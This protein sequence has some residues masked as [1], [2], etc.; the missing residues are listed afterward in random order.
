MPSPVRHDENGKKKLEHGKSVEVIFASVIDHDIYILACYM[1]Y[2]VLPSPSALLF[3]ISFLEDFESSMEGFLTQSYT[4]NCELIDESSQ[5][6]CISCTPLI[7]DSQRKCLYLIGGNDYH[8]DFRNNGNDVLSC[9]SLSKTGESEKKVFCYRSERRN[10]AIQSAAVWLEWF[11]LLFYTGYER[12]CNDVRVGGA[13]SQQLFRRHWDVALWR[14]TNCME[15]YREGKRNVYN[16]WNSDRRKEEY[17]STKKDISTFRNGRE[18]KRED[19]NDVLKYDP[20]NS[21]KNQSCSKC[22]SKERGDY[23]ERY[24]QN[25]RYCDRLLGLFSACTGH[26]ESYLFVCVELCESIWMGYCVCVRKS[27]SNSQPS[28]DISQSNPLEWK[29]VSNP[30][31]DQLFLVRC[32]F[33]WIWS[34]FQRERS[35]D[36]RNVV[37]TKERSYKC[38][39]S[40][41]Y[42]ERYINMEGYS[43]RKTFNYLYG[44]KGSFKLDPERKLQKP[45]HEQINS[46]NLENYIR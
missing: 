30:K 14:R 16:A 46:I 33:N 19:I 3:E 12:L 6:Y 20:E 13:S 43:K 37:R 7:G 27:P 28:M 26:A 1:I 44:I 34:V 29:G 31:F 42:L 45:Y 38:I 35:K 25:C 23:G 11:A 15:Q 9:F 40:K 18:S 8:G 21:N 36:S 41:S 22:K 32:I 39:G 5:Y 2:G 24:V 17:A 10:P 4:P